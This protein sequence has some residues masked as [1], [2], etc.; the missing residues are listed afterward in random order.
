MH[1]QSPSQS[2]S[3]LR[4]PSRDHGRPDRLRSADRPQPSTSPTS[5]CGSEPLTGSSRKLRQ[6]FAMRRGAHTLPRVSRR[7]A[8]WSRAEQGSD[9]EVSL[10]EPHFE[11][12]QVPISY[13]DAT[14]PMPMA[15]GAL[16]HPIALSVGNPHV[17]FFVDNAKGIRPRRLGPAHRARP[18]FHRPHQRQRGGGSSE[19]HSPAH[20]GARRRTDPACGTGAS[21]PPLRRSC[22][23]ALQSPGR[24]PCQAARCPSPGTGKADHACAAVRPMS[25]RARST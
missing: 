17:V 21:A 6:R 19:G 20:L 16:Q 12:D 10:G 23:S 4:A 8:A 3:R 14:N 7:T 9:I 15:L 5:G 13:A 1:G 11:W 18:I 22:P 25:S 2:T 24:S